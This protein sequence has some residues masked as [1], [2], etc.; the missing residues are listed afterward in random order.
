[1]AGTDGHYVNVNCK[2][3]AR[4]APG[5]VDSFIALGSWVNGTRSHLISVLELRATEKTVL[6]ARKGSQAARG[7]TDTNISGRWPAG[8]PE[9][10][11]IHSDNYLLSA[12][13]L[14]PFSSVF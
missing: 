5:H 1:M 2:G 10:P 11:N 3:F 6:Q 4:P 8:I 9:G 7:G 13:S 14:F 12:R